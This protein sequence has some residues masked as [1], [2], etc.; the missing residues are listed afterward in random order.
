MS[1]KSLRVWLSGSIPESVDGEENSLGEWRQE[2][3][4]D[5]KK[6]RYSDFSAATQG[7]KQRASE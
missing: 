7:S 3:G 5:G 1:L 4:K 6:K 2:G